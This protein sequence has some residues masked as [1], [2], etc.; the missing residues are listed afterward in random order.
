M[1]ISLLFLSFLHLLLEYRRHQ[2]DFLNQYVL[3]WSLFFHQKEAV[4]KEKRLGPL[5]QRQIHLKHEK[6]K[7]LGLDTP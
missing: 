6:G 1:I 2:D 5:F 7:N 3:C 4:H